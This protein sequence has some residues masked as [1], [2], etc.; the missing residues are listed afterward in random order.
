[1]NSED[2]KT[3][4]GEL[5]NQINRGKNPN[6]CYHFDEKVS[7]LPDK[8]EVNYSI[9]QADRPIMIN[10]GAYLP[11]NTQ[12]QIE[13]LADLRLRSILGVLIEKGL[14]SLNKKNEL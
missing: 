11:S 12:A 14:C 9:K 5:L 10:T 6:E 1:M 13:S 2:I 4:I 8:T 3:L 7:I